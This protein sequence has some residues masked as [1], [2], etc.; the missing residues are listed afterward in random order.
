MLLVGL[1]VG[2]VWVVPLGALASYRPPSFYPDDQW[3]RPGCFR[4]AADLASEFQVAVDRL[5][6]EPGHVIE[7]ADGT[8]DDLRGCV[9]SF[10][11]FDRNCP[12]W[13][14]Y[15]PGLSPKE[16]WEHLDMMALE[17]AR[18]DH[19]LK[20][21]QLGAASRASQER[22]EADSLEIAKATKSFTTVWTFVAVG[23]AGILVAIA[24]LTYL[25][26]Q[27]H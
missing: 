22:I 5:R 20:L 10:L 2:R 12:S 7:E 13:Y 4:F 14:P 9:A 24:I 23:L 6:A 3:T 25:H 26:I 21:A 18:R 19:D 16:H 15:L 8:Q 27:P 11:S 1:L 17:Q